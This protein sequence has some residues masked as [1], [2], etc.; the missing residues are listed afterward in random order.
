LQEEVGAPSFLWPGDV[1]DR[2]AEVSKEEEEEE[3]E[4]RKSG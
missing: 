1:P 2:G 4:R 3:E